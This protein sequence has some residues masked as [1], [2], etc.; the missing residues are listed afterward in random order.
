MKRIASITLKIFL[1]VLI[2]LSGILWYLYSRYEPQLTYDVVNLENRSGIYLINQEPAIKTF[3]AT[4]RDIALKPNPVYTSSMAKQ[5]NYGIAY[6]PIPRQYRS[7]GVFDTSH[8]LKLQQLGEK[9]FYP[10]LKNAIGSSKS[11]LLVIWVHGYDNSFTGTASVLAR[12]A[13]DLNTEATYL[14]FS[15]PSKHRLFSY[16]ADEETEKKSAPAFAQFLKQL[17]QEIPEAKLVIIAHS[18]GTRLI[19]DSFDILYQDKNWSDADNEIEDV[20]MI[21]PDVNEDDFDFEFKNQILSMVKRLTVYVA[22]DDQALLISHLEFGEKPLGLPTEFRSDS[23]LDETQALL[24]IMPNQNSHFN[25]IDA[26]YIVKPEFLKHRYYRSRAIV[27]DIY[28]LLHNT[29]SHQR[30]LYRSKLTPN[31]H[32]WILPP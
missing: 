17:H 26:T 13:Y 6:V 4:N 27:S 2:I 28:W 12:G 22:S 32:Y 25:I 15:W 3:F 7:G 16:T 30:Q 31:Q 11:K 20:I 23:H 9:N 14:F 10:S 8:L 29:P 5:L 24:A 1:F 21:A 19:C 18:L